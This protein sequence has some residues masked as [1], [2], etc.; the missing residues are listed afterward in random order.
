M[1]MEISRQHAAFGTGI[2]EV[3]MLNGLRVRQFE[4]GDAPLDCGKNGLR[5][6]G[7]IRQ[8]AD[9]P[10]VPKMFGARI[11]TTG[12][13]ALHRQ[14]EYILPIKYNGGS[15]VSSSSSILV[16]CITL[17]MPYCQELSWVS[18]GF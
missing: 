1:Q 4:G 17:I 9:F 7:D 8:N 14:H 15:M 13:L 11:A 10:S 12:I 5:Q 18:D 6:F 16:S 3:R 2:G